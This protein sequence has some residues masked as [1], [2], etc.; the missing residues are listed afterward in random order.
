[1]KN[2]CWFGLRPLHVSCS[3]LSLNTVPEFRLMHLSYFEWFRE[4]LALLE[5][6]SGLLHTRGGDYE[7]ALDDYLSDKTRTGQPFLY[8]MQILDSQK[9]LKGLA[10]IKFREVVLLRIPELVQHSR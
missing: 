8:I 3:I 1:L 4:M 5:Q 10:L 9:G 6:V 7:A 2:L